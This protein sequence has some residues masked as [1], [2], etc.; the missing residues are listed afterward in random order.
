MEMEA[1][2]EEALS[3]ASCRVERTLLCDER[4]LSDDNEHQKGTLKD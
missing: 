3:G 1:E 2:D 4:G